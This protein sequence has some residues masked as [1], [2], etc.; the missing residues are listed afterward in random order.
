MAP[1]GIIAVVAFLVAGCS[2][3]TG[4]AG[5]S[6]PSATAPRTGA[7]PPSPTSEPAA[8]RPEAASSAATQAFSLGADRGAAGASN[9]S[10]SSDGEP[11]T[12]PS[13]AA[14]GA[15]PVATPDGAAADERQERSVRVRVRRCRDWDRFEAERAKTSARARRV[16]RGGVHIDLEGFVATC[17]PR[18]SFAAFVGDGRLDVV[19]RP[20][21]PGTSRSLCVCSFDLALTVADVPAAV[22]EVRIF[23]R[24]AVAYDPP[25]RAKPFATAI[26]SP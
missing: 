2:S 18:P 25:G 5:R 22:S 14:T 24:I 4:G 15:A 20:P 17:E 16:K 7:T 19:E 23:D 13:G 9:A 8:A 3:G 26:L 12:E 6:T 1:R 21:E 11:R 10:G